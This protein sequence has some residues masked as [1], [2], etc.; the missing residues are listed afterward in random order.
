[1]ENAVEALKIA[2]AVLMFGMALT[3]SISSFSQATQAVDAITTLRDREAQYTYVKPTVGLTRNVGIDSVL[4]T[5]NRAFA[6]NMEIYFFDSHGDPIDL[7]KVKDDSG[8][9]VPTSCFDLA[10]QSFTSQKDK[11]IFW[12]LL[13]GG[14]GIE[15]EDII[16]D[17]IMDNDEFLRIKEEYKD[18]L[19][20]DYGIYSEFA[21]EEFQEQV[22]EYYDKKGAS[23]IKK[24]VITYTLQ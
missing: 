18:Y 5:M 13:V 20:H 11:V 21:G 9:L 10:N 17:K 7:Y 8:N 24:M 4:T 1:M 15:K 19:M 3:L 2:F 6:E 23:K 14:T 16:S 12:H 22:G